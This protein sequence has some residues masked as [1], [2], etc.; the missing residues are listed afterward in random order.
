MKYFASTVIFMENKYYVLLSIRLY[1]IIF[2]FI[3]VLLN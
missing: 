2:A 1:L 3:N